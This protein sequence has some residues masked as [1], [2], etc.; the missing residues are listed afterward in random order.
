[1]GYDV[2]DIYG[3]ITVS[4]DS[5]MHTNSIFSRAQITTDHTLRTKEATDILQRTHMP[6]KFV[7]LSI[8]TDLKKEHNIPNAVI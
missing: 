2:G 1:M 7:T 3:F 5:E 8:N 4:K 6:W